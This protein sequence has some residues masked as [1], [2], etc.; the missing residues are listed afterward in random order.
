MT[1][2][3]RPMKVRVF[4]EIFESA[5]PLTIFCS[6]QPLP[7]PKALVQVIQS[8]YFQFSGLEKN[9]HLLR[10]GRILLPLLALRKVANVEVWQCGAMECC[11]GPGHGLGSQ[12]AD[13]TSRGQISMVGRYIQPA[14]DGVGEGRK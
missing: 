14:D 13:A 7:L 8:L 5:S 2:I 9:G 1:L 4:G 6:S 10:R 11:V 3:S 12:G